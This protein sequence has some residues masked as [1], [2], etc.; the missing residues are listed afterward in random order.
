MNHVAAEHGKYTNDA[1]SGNGA[2]GGAGGGGASSGGGGRINH[3]AAGAVATDVLSVHRLHID[4]VLETLREEMS[5]LSEFE[6]LEEEKGGE[7]GT[8]TAEDVSRYID[9]VD[10]CAKG[11]L[12]V[13]G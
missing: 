7:H 12:R 2:G 4:E 8:L 6:K 5:L 1:D 10:A 9:A 3:A 11:I 13:P